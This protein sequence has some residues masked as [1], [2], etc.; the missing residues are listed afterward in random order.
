MRHP[1]LSALGSAP[2]THAITVASIGT[3]V[4]AFALQRVIGWPG[5][6][7]ALAILVVLATASFLG[8]RESSDWQGVL[9]ISLLAFLGW[10]GASIIWGQYQ[11]ATLGGLAYLGAYTVL[12]LY[13]A[14]TRDTIQIVRAFGDVLR[15]VLVASLVL[16]VVVGIILDTSVPLIDLSGTI[17]SGG[18]IEGLMGSRNHLGLLAVLAVITFGAE[19][20][21]QSV[22][23]ST[24]VVSLTAAGLALLFTRSPIAIAVLVLVGLA[25][26]ALYGI[27]RL[28]PPQRRTAQFVLLGTAAVASLAAWAARTPLTR[29]VDAVGEIDYRLGVWADMTDL[30]RLHT[31]E[32]WGWIGLWRV[33]L[34]PFSLFGT[35]PGPTPETGL[36]AFLDVWLQLGLVGAVIFVGMLG[37]TFVRSW[38]LAGIKRSFVFNWPALVM[39]ALV[40]TSLVESTI[41][42]QY[43]WLVFVVCC[44]KAAHELSWR[45]AFARPLE[46]PTLD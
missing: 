40:A 5:L 1:V 32:G 42:A 26:A 43:G 9:P 18:P 46:A 14:L 21:T 41:L 39:V 19:L 8:R 22:E 37:L 34:A 44:V 29:A 36:N 2:V 30:I 33:E 24:S 20:R 12:G 13:I 35:T 10:A 45:R 7:G 31:L 6:I 27:R 25:A 17:A 23:R 38:L 3:A 16:E 15:V 11:W 4:L 28:A